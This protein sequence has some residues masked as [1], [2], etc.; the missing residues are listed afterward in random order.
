MPVLTHQIAADYVKATDSRQADLCK[1][2]D[3][4]L[5]LQEQTRPHSLA[6]MRSQPISGIVVEEQRVQQY[7]HHALD[8]QPLA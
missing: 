4:L 8:E 3:V 1:R 7:G 5:L 2:I 6:L